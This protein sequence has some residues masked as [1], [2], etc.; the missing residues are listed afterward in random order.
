VSAD[1]L[2][3][4]DWLAARLPP[5]PEAFRSRLLEREPGGGEGAVPDRLLDSV[6]HALRDALAREGERGGAFRLLAADAWITWASEE[7]LGTEDPEAR[8]LD[9]LREVLRASGE[10]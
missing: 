6:G 2:P 1:D 8:L 10:R 3:L 5:V 7:A 9:V 4:Q